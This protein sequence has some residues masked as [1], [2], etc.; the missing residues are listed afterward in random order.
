MNIF[1]GR[2]SRLCLSIG[3]ALGG[4]AQTQVLAQEPAAPGQQGLDEIVVTGSRIARRDF[5]AQSPIVSV[6]S[7]TFTERTNIGMEAALNQLPQFTAAG[8]QASTSPAGTPFPQAGAAPGAATLNLR[9]LGTNRNL[10]LMDG[11]RVQPVNGLL[12]VDINT[13]PSAAI[14]R[15]E[16]ITGGA[17][18]VYGAD[19]IAGVTNFILRKD[20]EGVEFG[21][22]TGMSEEG[23]GEESQL[24]VLLG[25]NFADGRGNVMVGANYANREIILGKDRGWVVEGWNDPGTMGGGIGSSN[26]SQMSVT[27]GNAPTLFALPPGRNYVIDQNGNLFDSQDPRNPAR[28]YTGPLGSYPN[29]AGSA[30]KINPDGTL[31]WNDFEHRYLQLP[32]ER[33]SLFASGHI[34]LTDNVEVFADLR[35][36]ETYAESTGFVT[37]LFNIW[38]PTVPYDPANDDPD[39]ATFGAGSSDHP[40]PRA[41][42]DLLNSR[43]TPNGRWTYV[44]GMDYLPTFKTETT[45]NVYQLIAGLRGDAMVGARDWNWE[46]Y[47]SH[48]KTSVNAHQPEG[49][50]FLPRVQNLF[51]ANQYGENFD[52]SSLP[53]FVPIAV[54][55]HCTS[56][57]PLFDANG[58]VDNT[59]TVSQDCADWMV[60][61]MNSITT[62]TQEVVEG[63]VTGPIAELWA[64]E[65]QFA[66]GANY[67]QEDFAFAPDSGF[68][69]NQRFPDVI[70]NIILPVSVDGSTDVTEVFMELA[71]PLVSDRK[72][73]QSFEI[74]PGVRWSDYNT[75]G[76]VDTYK[77]TADW[78]VNDRVRVRGGHQFANRAP[79][80]TE[81]FTP[82][83]GS[84]LLPG[85]DACAYYALETP[86]WGNR[87]E[88]PNRFNLQTL[89]QHLMVRDGAP[90]NFYLPGVPGPFPTTF[91][92]DAY[93]YNVFG[94]TTFFP[95]TIGVTE[96]NPKLESESADTTTV[97]IVLRPADRLTLSLDW[98]EIKL[99]NAIGIPAY[100]T[101]YQQCLDAKYNKLIGDAP[102]SHT[103][104][105]LAAGN[106][107]CALI[108]REWVGGAPLTPGN[109]GASRRYSA[110]YLNQG[111]VDTE[112]IDLQVD[113]GIGNFTVN[114]VASYLDHISVAPFPGGDFI[115]YTG[116]TS[117]GLTGNSAFDF[118]TFSTVGYNAGRFS[119]GFRWQHQPELD[120]AP[121]TTFRGVD[122]HD[123][124]D[125]FG[126]WR[127]TDR[128]TLRGGIDNL[129]NEDPEWVNATATN[130]NIGTTNSDYDQIGRRYFIGLTVEL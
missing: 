103:G 78:E 67:R 54:T 23:D 4:T 66:A 47:A 116:T 56:G 32:L 126:M 111:G 125:V 83:G 117:N 41:F 33:Y 90:A 2:K 92:A 109:F 42:A 115:D 5:S 85:N 110:Q 59:P 51:D 16:V 114:L 94:A 49:F 6:D 129:T 12:V 40:V 73:V 69:A 98:Y 113:W 8:T 28:P 11:K 101:V 25:A 87:P 99:K 18:A 61:R 80:V 70:Q 75:V 128:L 46:V 118:R 91:G 36:S 76:S 26:L 13:I 68:N 30:F 22:Q 120:T 72:L 84:Q 123:Q 130:N 74:N 63:T 121:G 14:D 34:D 15:V 50:P 38:S 7:S 106:P 108:Q 119:I 81:L 53:G 3:L 122:A 44:G 52:V 20:F 79:N 104:A 107:F 55:G 31:G 10:V 93:S 96:G 124:F 112:G 127:P 86:T 64:G 82:R 58:N 45:S 88:N 95:F 57:L 65:L 35:F 37:Q 89:C 24:S 71:I 39:S 105:E 29:A 21:L 77:V 100:N 62:L 97:G 48:G 43:P 9:G 19:A 1:R 60:L 27:A 102:G 17:A